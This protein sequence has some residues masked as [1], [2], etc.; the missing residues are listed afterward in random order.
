MGAIERVQVG[1]GLRPLMQDVAAA[2]VPG[3]A[4]RVQ[5]GSETRLVA[6]G[7]AAASSSPWA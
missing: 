5:D 3:A 7:V 1:T 2:G 6:A 4:A